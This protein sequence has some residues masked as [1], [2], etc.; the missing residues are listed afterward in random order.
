MKII[1]FK[2]DIDSQENIAK[3]APSLDGSSAISSWHADVGIP[4][5]VLTMSGEGLEP[6]QVINLVEKAGFK[7]E[8]LRVQ[9]IGGGDL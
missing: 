5:N 6:Q 7:A 9:A 3:V 8:T 1:K 4:D 2:T